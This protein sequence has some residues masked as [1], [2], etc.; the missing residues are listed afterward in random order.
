VT[1]A[2]IR[3]RVSEPP[4]A[5][6][7]GQRARVFELSGEAFVPHVSG[8]L[9]WP[10]Q[11]TL[12]VA[13][14]HLEKGSAH[15]ERGVMLPPYDTAATLARLE[16][17]VAQLAP[18]RVVALGDSF[19]DAGAGA[20]LAATDRARLARLQCGRDWIWIAGNHDPR[21]PSGIGGAWHAQIA[22]G[23][24]VF[25]HEPVAGCAAG[26]IAGHLHPVARVR[27]KGHVL[28]RRCFACDDA[29]IV[30]P[31]FGAFTGGLNVLDAAYAG[32]FSGR[33]FSAFL[34]GARA[35]Y[36]I[37]GRRLVA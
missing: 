36:R 8:A 17:V 27:I 18:R 7:A 10:A 31:A 6:R 21:P 9:W 16:A 14:L 30:M 25:R 26:E 12:V 24:M 34:L 32:L 23:P 4:A 37:A 13:D 2:A 3:T 19:H 22:L 11:T 5:G 35:V 33:D 29:R 15:A 28:R 20:R 1:E